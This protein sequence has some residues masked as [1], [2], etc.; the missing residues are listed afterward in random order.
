MGAEVQLFLDHFDRG[1]FSHVG[2]SGGVI[3]REAN[4]QGADLFRV[5]A[6]FIS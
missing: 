4:L 6:N 5:E 1:P 2:S 3:F